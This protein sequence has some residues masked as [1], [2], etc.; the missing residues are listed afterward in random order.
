MRVIAGK[1]RGLRLDPPP[2]D[3]TRPITDRVKESIFSLLTHRLGTPG[4][5]PDAHVLDLFAGCGSFG[6]ESLSRGAASCLFVEKDGRTLRTLT[7]N[8]AKLAD[9]PSA[10]VARGSVWSMRFPHAPGDAEGYRVIFV[11][12][13][14]RDAHNATRVAGLLDRLASRLAP[15]GVILLRYELGTAAPDEHLM[16]LVRSEERTWG[17]MTVVIFTRP[18]A[19]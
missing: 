13:P 18:E 9:E 2:G 8:V 12:P 11:D 14:Y 1:H 17:R 4:F 3:Q 5:L 16:G 7:G 15:D 19:S 6:I 10:V